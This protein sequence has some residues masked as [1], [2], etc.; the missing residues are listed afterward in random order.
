MARKQYVIRNDGQYFKGRQENVTLWVRARARAKA[1]TKGQAEA[2]K[3]LNP[4]CEMLE[5]TWLLYD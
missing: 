5:V 1:L 3:R 2:M 4:L